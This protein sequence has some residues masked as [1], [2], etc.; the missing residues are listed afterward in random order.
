MII[1]K[2]LVMIM[3]YYVRKYPNIS[4]IDAKVFNEKIP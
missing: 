3:I 1:I 2:F 4:E